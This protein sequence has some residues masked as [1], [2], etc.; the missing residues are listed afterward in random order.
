[1]SLTTVARSG[2]SQSRLFPVSLSS[3][4]TKKLLIL[5]TG[6][7]GGLVVS[8][9]KSPRVSR[10]ISFGILSL[11]DI[12]ILAED[13]LAQGILADSANLVI[14]LGVV[15]VE[16]RIATELTQASSI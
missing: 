6:E 11:N 10:H 7:R 14:V 13:C 3:V 2:I 5:F 9:T 12:I 1:M 4:K 16:L 15:V 8:K